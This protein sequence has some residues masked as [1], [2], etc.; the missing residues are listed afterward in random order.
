MIWPSSLQLRVW[1]C[2][3]AG[4][5]PAAPV[6]A[7]ALPEAVRARV[8][9]LTQQCVRAGGKPGAPTGQGQFVIAADFNGDGQADFLVSE[10]N[11]PC[12]GQPQLFRPEGLGRVQLFLA[13]GAGGSWLAFDDRLLAY[14]VLE[15][16]PARLQI[17][18][19]APACGGPQRCGDELVWNASAR[20]FDEKATDGRKLALRPAAG[21]QAMPVAAPAATPLPAASGS[22][23]P[24]PAILP[25]AE[26]RFRES[27]R[28]QTLADHGAQAAKW[29]A[30]ACAEQWKKVVAAQPLAEALLA[31][32]G[33]GAGPV[34]PLKR[35]LP[36]VRW[37]PRA[38][39]GELAS[40]RLGAYSA[41]LAG[42]AGRADRFVASWRAT[43]AE[44]PVDLP[45]ALETRGATIVRTSCAKLG[46]GEGERAWQVSFPGRPPFELFIS[47]R[48]APTAGAWTYWVAEGRLDARPAR[49]GAARCEPFW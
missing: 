29:V 15:G 44:I 7:Q 3:A 36:A 39:A 9:E 43:G 27:C 49:K 34:D 8:V 6:A 23:G 2:L 41:G 47:E 38:D 13:D 14:R 42:G 31:A 1:C 11:Y 21:G 45:G 37:S 28:K 32:N 10:G 40:G 4:L 22:P 17:A 12:T 24:V 48:T 19:R 5:L 33:V 16:A 25:G 20:R 35:A 26:D 30:E 46:V 18:R